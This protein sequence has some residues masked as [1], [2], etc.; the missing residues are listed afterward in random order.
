MT[1]QPA[2]RGAQTLEGSAENGELQPV[3]GLALPAPPNRD[4]RTEGRPR[5]HGSTFYRSPRRSGRDRQCWRAGRH[6]SAG[7]VQA[8]H[9]FHE[10]PGQA[11]QSGDAD[12]LARPKRPLRCPVA[13]LSD[14]HRCLEGMLAVV[15]AGPSQGRSAHGAG[16]ARDERPPRRHRRLHVDDRHRCSGASEAGRARRRLVERVGDGHSDGV[17]HHRR[18]RRRPSRVPDRERGWQPVHRSADRTAGDDQR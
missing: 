7:A 8:H 16:K 11:H 14:R 15:E 1:C 13:D 5:P 2:R 6:R 12:V 18:I 10:D 9:P 17:R 3:G 4:P